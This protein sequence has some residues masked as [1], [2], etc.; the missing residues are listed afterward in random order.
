V[1]LVAV[2]G[3][4]AAQQAAPLNPLT[5]LPFPD[6]AAL[7]RRPLAVKISNGPAVVRPQA[8]IAQADLV[9]EHVTEGNITRFT[10]IFYSQL[11]ARVGSIRSARLIDLDLIPMYGALLAFA[12][13]SDG[14]RAK[15]RSADFAPRAF[16]GVSVGEPTYVRDPAI[17]SPHNLFLIPAQL[18]A[19]AEQ[20]GVNS[21]DALTGMAFNATMP[22]YQAEAT[23]SGST[24]TIDYGPSV[25]EWRY[26]PGSGRYERWTDDGRGTLD[27]LVPHTDALTGETVSAA[28]VVLIYARHTLDRSIIEGETNGVLYYSMNIDLSERGRAVICREGRCVDGLWSRPDRAAMLTFW[29]ASGKQTL[30]LTPGNTWFQVVNTPDSAEQ[31]QAITLR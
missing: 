22:T 1:L 6:P 26:E 24:I 16:E 2:L 17:R 7:S 8:G 21:P 23:M 27:G 4:R 12:G 3:V 30:A 5:G 31:Q 15:I 13:A 20:R 28:N 18:L 11:P 10:A 14:V 29:T 25:T 9:F 19:L